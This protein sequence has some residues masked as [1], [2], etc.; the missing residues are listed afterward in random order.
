MLCEGGLLVFYCW[1]RN[2]IKGIKLLV[3]RDLKWVILQ[4]PCL[5]LILCVS[6]IADMLELLIAA[7]ISTS[8]YHWICTEDYI[9]SSR[10]CLYLFVISFIL[11][12]QIWGICLRFDIGW[13][14]KQAI[15]ALKKG[16]CLLKYGRRGKPK[17]CPFRLSNVSL[18]QNYRNNASPSLYFSAFLSIKVRLCIPYLSS[19]LCDCY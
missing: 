9:S 15:T 5:P 6:W 3:C 7:E 19:L 12:P 13:S 2:E 18:V 16:A 10:R 14:F 4:M 11:H 8:S 1:L 17:F